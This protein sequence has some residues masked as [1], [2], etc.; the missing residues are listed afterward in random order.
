M[1]RTVRV[2]QLADAVMEGLQEYAKLATDD[3]KKD[4][5]KA[6]KA[7]QAQIKDTAPRKTGR[8]AKSWTSRKTKETSDSVSYSVHSKNRYMLTHLLENGHAKRGGGRVRAIPH[9]APAE[10]TGA[11]QLVRDIERDLKKGG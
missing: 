4:V 11:E 5:Q 10:K 6:A 8:Y 3:L 9:I 2:D 1:S 7:V